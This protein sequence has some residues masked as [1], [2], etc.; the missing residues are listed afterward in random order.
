MTPTLNQKINEDAAQ[1]STLFDVFRLLAVFGG[2]I[3]AELAS[4]AAFHLLETKQA[5]LLLAGVLSIFTIRIYKAWDYCTFGKEWLK[6]LRSRTMPN[7]NEFI[8][9]KKLLSIQAEIDSKLSKYIVLQFI[10]MLANFIPIHGSDKP[11]QFIVAAI[12]ALLSFAIS[13][14]FPINVFRRFL[15]NVTR[16]LNGEAIELHKDAA[17]VNRYLIIFFLPS[18]IFIVA[19]GLVNLFSAMLAMPLEG[20]QMVLTLTKTMALFLNLLLSALFMWILFLIR[21]IALD[22][23]ELLDGPKALS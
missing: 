1:L 9:S 13:V 20:E 8:S 14:R 18:V 5:A 10:V 15:K 17:A 7:T 22:T 16:R 4:L 11:L 2:I 19:G 3:C 21:R 6:G 23:A 12:L